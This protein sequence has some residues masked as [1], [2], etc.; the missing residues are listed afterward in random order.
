MQ[1]LIDFNAEPHYNG[2]LDFKLYTY[3]KSNNIAEQCKGIYVYEN[4]V[5]LTLKLI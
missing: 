5:V 2:V 4:D 3:S 1:V